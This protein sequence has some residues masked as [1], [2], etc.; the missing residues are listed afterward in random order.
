MTPASEPQPSAQ[1]VNLT[2]L[3]WQC[4]NPIGP[5]GSQQ[6]G[7]SFPVHFLP[8]S[9]QIVPVARMF[10]GFNDNADAEPIIA[11]VRTEERISIDATSGIG[12]FMSRIQWLMSEIQ[13]LM[14]G[15]GW[16]MSEIGLL[17]SGIGWLLLRTRRNWQRLYTRYTG[18]T[19][20][21]FLSNRLPYLETVSFVPQSPRIPPDNP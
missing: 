16:L 19:T 12:W 6:S 11:I 17:T 2:L 18:E 1:E 20:C 14:S 7:A 13:Q 5:A 21:F 4:A 10:K 15:T 8:T 9:S 3:F